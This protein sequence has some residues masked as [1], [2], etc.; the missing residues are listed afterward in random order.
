MYLMTAIIMPIWMIPATRAPMFTFA[1]GQ[2]VMIRRK[3]YEVAGGYAA[4]SRRINDDIG[5]ARAVRRAGFRSIFLDARRQIRC[6]MY[7]G[8]RASF[9]GLTRSIGEFINRQ[10]VSLVS[11]SIAVALLFL[12]PYFLLLPCLLAGHTGPSIMA[13]S[14]LLFQLTWCAVLYDR[15]LRWYVPFLYPA[16]FVLGVVMMWRGYG[17]LA[18]GT[19]LVWKGRVVT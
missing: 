4:V 11:G 8:F 7:D 17:K 18:R 2:L 1:I 14:V 13:V 16:M 15:G 6:R 12:L 10:I 19:G 5:M 3:A 9:N